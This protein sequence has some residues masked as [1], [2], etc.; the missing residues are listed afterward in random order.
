[1]IVLYLFL[2][3]SKGGLQKLGNPFFNALG[4][5]V[6]LS[7][8]V[9]PI[10]MMIVYANNER[11]VFMTFVGNTYLGIGHLMVTFLM[12]FVAYLFIEW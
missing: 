11:G 9:S 7:Y 3:H 6:Y 12:G 2:G 10:I 4:K 8:L 1:L 5:L